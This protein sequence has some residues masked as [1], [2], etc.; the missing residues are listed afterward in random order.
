M[1]TVPDFS[2]IELGPR[3]AAGDHAAWADA[4]ATHLVIISGE[5]ADLSGLLPLVE[6]SS[7]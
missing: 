3:A 2:G 1:A 7:K 6:P 4:V 5:R